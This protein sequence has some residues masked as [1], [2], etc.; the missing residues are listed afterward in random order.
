MNL[1]ENQSEAVLVGVHTQLSNDVTPKSEINDLK[2][3]Q[4]SPGNSGT[5]SE[6]SVNTEHVIRNPSSPVN[7]PDNIPLC[8]AYQ[9]ISEVNDYKGDD[10]QELIEHTVDAPN[11]DRVDPDKSAI[12]NKVKVDKEP[13]VEDELAVKE[14]HLSARPL[15]NTG[16]GF[17]AYDDSSAGSSDPDSVGHL[18]RDIWNNKIDFLLACIGFSVGLGN[19]WRFPYL[20]Y[21]NGGGL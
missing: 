15:V 13:I 9:H 5:T 7:P 8:P 16:N 21:K 10:Q 20:C 6:P 12:I 11:N 14:L 4:I 18:K 19:V 17:N 2:T 3:D 1:P